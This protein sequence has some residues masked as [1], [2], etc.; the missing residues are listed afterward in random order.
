MVE[1]RKTIVKAIDVFAKSRMEARTGLF[2]GTDW[3]ISLSQTPLTK[4]DEDKLLPNE[5]V[6]FFRMCENNVRDPR[7]LIIALKLVYSPSMGCASVQ[8]IWDGFESKWIGSPTAN[9]ISG[10]GSDIRAIEAH[11]LRCFSDTPAPSTSDEDDLD[12]LNRAYGEKV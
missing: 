5:Y 10:D 2:D 7:V 1:M 12:Q 9:S 3:Q 8:C 6:Y 4:E 11:L